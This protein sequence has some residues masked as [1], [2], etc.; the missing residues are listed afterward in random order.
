[1]SLVKFKNSLLTLILVMTLICFGSCNSNKDEIK[2]GTYTC[3][4][5][6]ITVTLNEDSTAVLNIDD[7]EALSKSYN[8]FLISQCRIFIKDE[9]ILNE[10]INE[11]EALDITD[12]INKQVAVTYDDARESEGLYYISFPEYYCLKNDEI[13]VHY[14]IIFMY[15]PA[16]QELVMSGSCFNDE[17]TQYLFVYE[18]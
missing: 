8:E 4:G 2:Y 1:M 10:K 17:N 11:I 9:N 5:K 14:S 16:S 18:A 13:E 12:S 6:S 15:Y 7:A 3:A